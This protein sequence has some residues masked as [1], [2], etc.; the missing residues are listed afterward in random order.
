VKGGSVTRSGFLGGETDL[1]H[2]GSNFLAAASFFEV[3]RIVESKGGRREPSALRWGMACAGFGGR[4]GV[5]CAGGG[6]EVR[7]AAGVRRARAR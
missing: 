6:G 3:D 4:D 5:V 7:R 1:S 2:I